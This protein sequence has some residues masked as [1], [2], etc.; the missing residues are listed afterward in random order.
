ME[1]RKDRGRFGN[2]GDKSGITFLDD[3]DKAL[4]EEQ[5][6]QRQM[7]LR[8]HGHPLKMSAIVLLEDGASF[9]GTAVMSGSLDKSKCKLFFTGEDGTELGLDAD[10]NLRD[11]GAGKSLQNAV[12]SQLEALFEEALLEFPAW[13]E[14]H[15]ASAGENNPYFNLDEIR[16]EFNYKKNRFGIW[17][18]AAQIGFFSGTIPRFASFNKIV[19]LELRETAADIE[20]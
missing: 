20:A 18:K 1:K 10:V 15:S 19:R 4:R 3:T 7:A 17:R 11:C 12:N 13:L 8:E 2:R 16:G 5:R 14:K 9:E 6:R